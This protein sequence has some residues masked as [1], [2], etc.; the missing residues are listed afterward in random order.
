[1]WGAPGGVNKGPLHMEGKGHAGTGAFLPVCLHSGK[2]KYQYQARAF[3]VKRGIKSH[4]GTYDRSP[5][6][7][8]SGWKVQ[9]IVDGDRLLIDGLPSQSNKQGAGR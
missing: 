6:I 9:Q 8:G 4:Q 2:G 3:V 1:M 5:D 7:T